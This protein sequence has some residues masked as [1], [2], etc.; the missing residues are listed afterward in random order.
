MS[1]SATGAALAPA[2]RRGRGLRRWL[3][4]GGF[5]LGALLVLAF[6]GLALLGPD[7][8]LRLSRSSSRPPVRRAAA[9]WLARLT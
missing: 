3:G 2:A 9:Q 7:A 4:H 1:A 8:L 5:V 6:V